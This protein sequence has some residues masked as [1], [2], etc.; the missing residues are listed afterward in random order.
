MEPGSSRDVA[1]L[2]GGADI[3]M[4]TASTGSAA[5][6]ML[7]DQRFDCVVVAAALPDMTA[8]QLVEH[9]AE[10]SAADG[11]AVVVYAPDGG[12]GEERA[13]LK[14]LALDRVV[15]MATSRAQLLDESSLFLHREPMRM[16]EGARELLIG[17]QTS[18][19]VLAGK[20]ILVVD[21]DVRNI[22]ALSSVLE[23]HGM[24]VVSAHTGSDAIRLLEEEADLELVL[25]DIMMPE[26]DGYETMRRIRANPRFRRLPIVTL[27]AKAMKGDREKC[28][29]AGASDYIAK[30]VDSDELLSLLRVWLWR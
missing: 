9:V 20:R 7:A 5:L 10:P 21:D 11:T 30:P 2:L 22:F 13:R 3:D 27:T 8:A 25:L 17:L 26:M 12:N 23:R 14:S 18:D 4:A 16:P 29:E 28:L 15:A 6:A 24:S 19:R 1:D